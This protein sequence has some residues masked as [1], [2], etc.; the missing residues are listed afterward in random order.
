MTEIW[1]DIEGFEGKYQISNLGRVKTLRR[2]YFSGVNHSQERIQEEKIL[3]QKVSKNTGYCIVLLYGDRR[4][5]LTVH[6]L[7]AE[8]FLPKIL[9]R[10]II[11]HKD[12]NKQNNRVDNLEWCT[13]SENT[14]HAINQNLR[15]VRKIIECDLLGNELRIWDSVLEASEY[16]KVTRGVIYNCI[17]GRIKSVKNK[18]WKY[19]VVKLRN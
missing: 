10:D 16:Y 2:I 14:K 12:G 3:S 1:K 13:Y 11:N 19:A 17:K 8:A 5:Y 6:R 15:P 9:G 18:T 4:H 7:V